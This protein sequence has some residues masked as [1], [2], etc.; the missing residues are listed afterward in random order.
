M[1]A[2]READVRR[3]LEDAQ[4]LWQ[5]GRRE[6]AFILALVSVS[7]AA[8]LTAPGLGDRAAFEAFLASRTRIRL[9]LEYQGQLLTMES[10]LYKLLRC[11]LIHEAGMASDVEFMDHPN[12]QDLI[13]RA[14]GAPEYILQL[15]P[16]WFHHLTRCALEAI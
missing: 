15:S 13:A 14:G 16:G 10:I 12:D 3:R 5:L 4:L 9:S 11:Q 7:A 2:P 6:S 8:R 1:G